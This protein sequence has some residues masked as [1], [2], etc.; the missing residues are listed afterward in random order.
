[1]LC[2]ISGEAPQVPVASKKSGN[3]FERRLIEAYLAE[4]GK[5]PVTGEELTTDDLIELKT[6]RIVRPRPPTLTSIPS[7]LSV[8]QNEWDAVALESSSLRQILAQTRQELSTALYQHDAAVRVIARLSQERDEARDALS[9]LSVGSG[10]AVTNGDDRMLVDQ[11]GLPEDMA[12]KVDATQERL[13]KTRRKRAVPDDWATAETLETLAP[14]FTSLALYPGGRS[15]AVDA[16]DDLV[17]LGGANGEAGIYSI[18]QNR[19]TQPLE[20]AHGRITDALFRG[21]EAILATGAGEVLVFD[22]DGALQTTFTAH[23][24]EVTALALHPSGDML[25]SVGSDKSYAWYDLW[26]RQSITHV[27][28]D[29]SLTTAAFHPDGHLFAAGT[30]RGQIHIFD[31]KTGVKAATFDA[32]GALTTIAFSENGTWLATASDGPTTITIWNL[33][34]AAELCTLEMSSVVACLRW[35][36]TGQFLAAA[37]SHGV[38]VHAYSKASKEWSQPL[39]VAVPALA[40]EWG[41]RASSLITRGGDGTVTVLKAP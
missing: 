6:A 38:T 14:A 19:V 22:D 1:M 12:A 24:G 34:T 28:T 33:R 11:P 26:R 7:L 29:S 41:A 9:K 10:G 25:A 30:T 18:S 3:V 17:L 15:L 35:D 23:A 20:G 32:S 5:D 16:T 40:V 13:S 31:V 2:A 8:F 37:G 36:Y 27:E 21:R 39:Q 4:H